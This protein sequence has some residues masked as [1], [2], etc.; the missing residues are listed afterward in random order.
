MCDL[1]HKCINFEGNE[2]QCNDFKNISN[3]KPVC[4]EEK[5]MKKTDKFLTE[6]MGEC[7]HDPQTL[8]YDG[9]GNESFNQFEI[10]GVTRQK[11]VCG[12]C[13]TR[14][15]ENNNFLTWEGFGKLWEWAEEQ[16][17]FCRFLDSLQGPKSHYI[18]PEKF[19]KAVAKY[20]QEK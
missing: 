4:K 7:W 20:L 18:D 17:W 10:K 5:S 8:Y 1:D 3:G 6:A 9:K 15:Y 14:Y 11:K 13:K 12:S 19:A 16:L 2:N